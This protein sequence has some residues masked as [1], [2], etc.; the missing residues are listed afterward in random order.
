VAAKERIDGTSRSFKTNS[1]ISKGKFSIVERPDAGLL[2]CWIK[3]E[4]TDTVKASCNGNLVPKSEEQ[5]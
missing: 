1:I 2:S 4:A 3:G 5:L